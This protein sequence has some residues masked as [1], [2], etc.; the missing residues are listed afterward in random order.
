MKTK[1]LNFTIFCWSTGPECDPA[2][3][4]QKTVE[5][6]R[7]I[8]QNRIMP[9]CPRLAAPFVVLIM[10]IPA[11]L[12]ADHDFLQPWQQLQ[13]DYS[14]RVTDSGSSG[15]TGIPVI[16]AFGPYRAVDYIADAWARLDR[17]DFGDG[18]RNVLALRDLED[19]RSIPALMRYGLKGDDRAES[20]RLLGQLGAVRAIPAIVP[21]LDESAY[22]IRA[23][24]LEG[25]VLMRSPKA[26][27]G[28]V[29]HGERI[30]PLVKT[31][32]SGH[33][34]FLTDLLSG[35]GW[36]GYRGAIPFLRKVL[37]Y[38]FPYQD[39]TRT[40]KKNAAMALAMLG[41]RSSSAKIAALDREYDACRILKLPVCLQ[42]AK[43]ILIDPDYGEEVL[44]QGIRVELG[45]ARIVAALRIYAE[46]GSRGDIAFLR[47]RQRQI[48]KLRM[49]VVTGDEPPFGWGNYVVEN[50][51]I[52]VLFAWAR[53]AV[54]D[55]SALNELDGYLQARD[56]V[57][58]S[59][60]ARAFVL[61]KRTDR[62]AA[63][64]AKLRAESG[65]RSYDCKPFE[66]RHGQYDRAVHARDGM[67]RLLG[68]ERSTAALKLLVATLND[69]NVNVIQR[70]RRSI[71]AYGAR[72]ALS[73]LEDGYAGAG[74]EWERWQLATMMELL[75]KDGL[76][77]LER[78]ART[79]PNPM[80][81]AVALRAIVRAE[82]GDWRDLL[83]K[84][85]SS[86]DEFTRE[87][88]IRWAEYRFEYAHPRR[89]ANACR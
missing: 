56:Y 1:A 29:A 68:E 28:M 67:M 66:R 70:A 86:R 17:S 58:A 59:E 69:C 53:A 6:E 15:Y 31:P 22:E 13:R 7:K 79:D 3:P 46:M 84:A 60:A 26:G 77:R 48:R 32:R 20:A 62:Y 4:G 72:R 39:K 76:D 45:G 24:A 44:D 16:R 49:D 61:L 40:H 18:G 71:K 34:A 83:C 73:A 27:P 36:T 51:N 21:L 47:A 52:P 14:F 85:K 78:I 88:L 10:L 2:A 50:R 5:F 87:N 64:A 75:G 43:G 55:A 89:V 12:R 8:D 63:I 54:G 11:H 19:P 30:L 65:R 80:G 42:R 57:V 74:D 81:R 82:H 38:D 9:S 41:D 33:G 23:K 25:L 35:L 37:D